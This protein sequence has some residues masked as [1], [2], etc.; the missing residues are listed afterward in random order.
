MSRTAM[1]PLHVPVAGAVFLLIGLLVGGGGVIAY[2][3][4]QRTRSIIIEDQP[5]QGAVRVTRAKLPAGGF[6]LVK[7]FFPERGIVTTH[8]SQ[9]LYPAEYLQFDIEPREYA[10]SP[11]EGALTIQDVIP[12]MM[13]T[14]QAYLDRGTLGVFEGESI[15]APMKSILGGDIEATF[16]VN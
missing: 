8:I 10:V 5:P 1:K 15:E 2:D 16:R 6:I 9:Y 13:L 12:G 7:A 14:A 4:Y 11:E 3:R